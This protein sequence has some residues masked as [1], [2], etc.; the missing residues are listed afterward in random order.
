MAK[1][2]ID[3]WMCMKRAT[4]IAGLITFLSVTAKTSMSYF[5]TAEQQ[6]EVQKAQ[7]LTNKKL[8]LTNDRLFLNIRQDLVDVK[9]RDVMWM[10]Q[11]ITT[12]RRAEPPTAAEDVILA[13]AETELD[14]QKAL[15][16]DLIANFEKKNKQQF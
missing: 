1:I 11:Q 15:Q 13:K 3:I 9:E 2:K 10:Q 16:R 6:A 5:A 7:K 4:V 8:E 12:Q 14:E